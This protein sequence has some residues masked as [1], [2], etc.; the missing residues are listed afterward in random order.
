M[1]VTECFPVCVSTE[2][3]PEW[4]PKQAVETGAG[5]TI[6]E[7]GGYSMVTRADGKATQVH[8]SLSRKDVAGEC[9]TNCDLT[10]HRDHF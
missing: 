10:K 7:H 1:A 4:I 9:M 3:R 2:V 8:T 5:D 6:V